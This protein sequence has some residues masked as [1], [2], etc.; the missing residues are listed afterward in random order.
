M[1]A[2]VESTAG[3]YCTE[4]KA[5][6]TFLKLT[7][8]VAIGSLQKSKNS[9]YIQYIRPPRYDSTAVFRFNVQLISPSLKML[10]GYQPL[11]LIV[12]SWP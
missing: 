9:L 8:R 4:S 5:F 10:T 12:A 11:R 6:F 2:Y 1:G 3:A 7:H